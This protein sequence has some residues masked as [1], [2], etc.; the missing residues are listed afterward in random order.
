MELGTATAIAA[1]LGFLG[2]QETNAMQAGASQ[3]QMDFQERMSNTAYQR[4]VADL[5]ASG[6]NPM[7]AY[8]KGG[9]AS[10]PSGAIPTFQSPVSSAVEAYK[11]VSQ[12]KLTNAQ[13]GLTGAQTSK[14]VAEIDN[15]IADTA[16]KVAQSGKTEADTILVNEMVNR[17]KAEISKITADTDVARAEIAR[18]GSQTDLNEAQAENLVLERQ[19]IRA[20]IVN[21]AHSSALMAQ[22][23]MTEVARRNN[24]NEA[25]DKLYYEKLI[26]GAEYKAMKDSNFVGVLAREVKVVS[27]ITS[28]YIDKLLPWK[29]GKQT[30]EE[31]TDIVRDSKGR[32]VGRSTY[33]TKR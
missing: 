29:Q 16:L 15:T 3:A 23:G 26:T 9:G 12:A 13:T 1:G 8:I 6:L 5:Q 19:R 21:L 4:Q 32:E 7:L 24:L 14:T 27:D 28:E 31:H 25:S 20:T 33:R 2:Q 17:T 22:Q 18:I 11:G 10:T 30:S